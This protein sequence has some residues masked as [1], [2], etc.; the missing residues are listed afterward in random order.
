MNTG[1]DSTVPT[2]PAVAF[3]SQCIIF[4][5]RFPHNSQ[6]VIVPYFFWTLGE[7]DIG[8]AIICEKPSRDLDCV[9]G[10]GVDY[11]GKMNVSETGKP[12]LHWDDQGIQD[13]LGKRGWPS[14]TVAKSAVSDATVL[15]GIY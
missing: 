2:I 14:V 1:W 6:C 4:R 7:C 5:N 10:K 13:F 8:A 15:P 9:I 3:Y 11:K 12:C